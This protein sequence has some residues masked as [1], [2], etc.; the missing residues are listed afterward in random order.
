MA[1]TGQGWIQFIK[2]NTNHFNI[3]DMIKIIVST[4][5][6]DNMFTVQAGRIVASMGDINMDTQTGRYNENDDVR[7]ICMIMILIMISWIDDNAE[8]SQTQATSPRPIS[9]PSLPMMSVNLRYRIS[10]NL[11]EK[12]PHDIPVTFENHQHDFFSQPDFSASMNM[13]MHGLGYPSDP[14][15]EQWQVFDQ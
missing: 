6:I 10:R 11:A 5:I 12:L 4:I 1:L 8:L 3:I 15:A 7:M 9:S 2:I 13:T 14:L